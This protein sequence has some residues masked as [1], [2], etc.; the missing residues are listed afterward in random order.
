MFF[1]SR[2]SLSRTIACR[3]PAGIRGFCTRVYCLRPFLTPPW[4]SHTHRGPRD[5]PTSSVL[6]FIRK[7][8]FV[9]MSSWDKFIR[10][11]GLAE[12]F[13]RPD[14]FW[15]SSKYGH[16]LGK[17]LCSGLRRRPRR[18]AHGSTDLALRRHV[19]CAWDFLGLVNTSRTSLVQKNERYLAFPAAVTQAFLEVSDLRSQFLPHHL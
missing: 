16:I 19:G 17:T 10:V 11:M 6:R 18:Q 2:N 3:K 14:Y 13:C 8:Q 12:Y 4:Q 9:K 7:K 1:L 5:H 15:F